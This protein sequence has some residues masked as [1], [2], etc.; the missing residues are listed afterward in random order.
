MLMTH[1][2]AKI[3]K[4]R[5][6]GQTEKIDV[7]SFLKLLID[8]LIYSGIA[9]LFS[10]IWFVEANRALQLHYS[11][12]YMWQV[13]ILITLALLLIVNFPKYVGL[14]ALGITILST[15][16]GY[17]FPNSFLGSFYQGVKFHLSEII[18]SFVWI[19]SYNKSAMPSSFPVYLAVFSILIALL[20]IYVKPVPI[21]LSIFWLIPYVSISAYKTAEISLLNLFIGLFCIAVTFTR[22]SSFSGKWRKIWQIPPLALIAILLVCLFFL[23]NLLPADLFFNTKLNRYLDELIKSKQNM[24]DT[25][26]YYEFSIKDAGFYPQ[27]AHLG[28]PVE[29]KN[30]PFMY[31]TGPGQSFYLRGTVFNEF[32]QNIWYASNMDINYLFYNEAPIRQQKEAFQYRESLNLSDEIFQHYFKDASINISPVY[33][34][35]QAIFH[36]GKPEQILNNIQSET[37]TTGQTTATDAENSPT[38]NISFYFNPDGQ[39]YASDEIKVPGYTVKGQINTLAG[40]DDYLNL[41][42]KD[43]YS[44]KISF[45]SRTMKNNKNYRS[46]LEN[47]EPA[48]AEIVYQKNAD[49]AL[50]LK[51]IVMYL[52]TNYVYNLN[53]SEIPESVD[54]FEHFISTRNGYCTYFATALTI[55]LR[56]AG[57]EARYIEGFL[58]PGIQDRGLPGEYYKRLV[59]SDQAHAWTEVKVNELGYIP[60]D[61]TPNSGLNDLLRDQQKEDELRAELPETTPTETLPSK[62]QITLPTTTKNTIKPDGKTDRPDQNKL[63]NNLTKIILPI[64]SILFLIGLIILYI[65]WRKN[66]L[67]NK[68]DREWLF[69]KFDRDIYAVITYIWLDMKYLYELQNRSFDNSDTI[70]KIIVHMAEQFNFDRTKAHRA[71][72]AIDCVFYAEKNPEEDEIQ[73]LLEMYA[74]AEHT[75][76]Q[77]LNQVKWFFRRFLFAKEPRF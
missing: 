75:T 51:N 13:K 64:F 30:L 67:R 15:F 63:N 54:L 25:V 43:Y 52:K 4:L 57:F 12:T 33:Q 34:P 74:A 31:V 60:L 32:E 42:I 29:K 6:K 39:I 28:G 69:K 36:G 10:C 19:F 66:L 21:L 53:V 38:D 27:N 7:Q 5:K 76:R 71:Y 62:S 14:P 48:L 45:A 11:A 8:S 58:V 59:S 3:E 46:F 65:L 49:K 26:K 9:F 22:Q 35:I 55:L 70:L 18:H 61:A 1:E 50:Q 77:N 41:I 73:C 2:I 24:P 20:L 23:Q 47:T 44:E 72:L 37:P 16:V 68:H 56:E 17:I 40:N